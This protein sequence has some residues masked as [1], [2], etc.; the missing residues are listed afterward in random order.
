MRW[1]WDGVGDGDGDVYKVG[2]DGA[3]V[4]GDVY[5]VGDG[6]GVGDGDACME[7]GLGME[8]TIMG[9]GMEMG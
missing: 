5:K 2:G 1:G 4:I 3:G 6:D 9:L 8:T 7:I